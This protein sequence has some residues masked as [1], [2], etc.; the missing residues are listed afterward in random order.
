[1]R[2]AVSGKQGKL[3]REIFHAIKE[4]PSG[5]GIAIVV[6][7]GVGSKIWIQ[8]WIIVA[9]AVPINK[10]SVNII[11][12]NFETSNFSSSANFFCRDKLTNSWIYSQL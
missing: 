11:R 9:A 8:T 7:V 4:K 6:A 12:Y 2:K 3:L 5:V 10:Y 1:M